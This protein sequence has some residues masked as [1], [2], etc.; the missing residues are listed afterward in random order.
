MFIAL[1]VDRGNLSNATSDNFLD[2]LGLT[3]NDYNAGNTIFRVAFLLAEIPS[4]LISKALGPDIFIP[5]Q[6]C[7]WS[8]VAMCQAALSGK[9]SFCHKVIDWGNRRR[10][11]RRLG[12]MVELLFTGKELPVRLSWFWTTLS[13]VDIFNSLAAFGILRMRGLAGMAGW[14]W[15]FLL[16]GAFTLLIGIFSFYLMV[17]S[18]VQTKNWMHPKGWFTD[19]EVKIVVNRILRDDPTKGS[20][21]NRQGLT[22]KQIIKSFR[23]VDI[24]PLIAIGPLTSLDLLRLGLISL[25]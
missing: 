12:V 2:D 21:H 14:R 11:H 22:I 17:P 23:D 13:L 6:I 1:Q 15:L 24:F 18:A 20:M 9:A 5:I 10:F 8:I 16:E 3:T 7:A 19:R 4:Q 25:Y